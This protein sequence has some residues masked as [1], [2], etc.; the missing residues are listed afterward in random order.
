M[1]LQ[2]SNPKAQVYYKKGIA[3]EAS[4]QS[5][6]ACKSYE[7][8]AHLEP[9]HPELWCRLGLLSAGY[10]SKGTY[11][12]DE[13]FEKA[14]ACS[15]STAEPLYWR[16]RAAL[17]SGLGGALPDLVAS[18][19]LDPEPTSPAVWETYARTI[20]GHLGSLSEEDVRWFPGWEQDSEARQNPK[21]SW[22]DRLL[23]CYNRA[24]ALVPN[25]GKYYGDRGY[26]YQEH[27]YLVE[28]LADYNVA[29]NHPADS[30]SDS[31][32][33]IRRGRVRLLL[34]DFAGA[35][36]DFTANPY[37]NGKN[38]RDMH[39]HIFYPDPSLPTPYAR[40]EAALEAF[41]I[42][43]V[44]EPSDADYV[45]NRLEYYLENHQYRQALPDVEALIARQPT[46]PYFRI[47]H[48]ACHLQQPAPDF[49]VLLSEFEWL[50]GQR[51]KMLA[52]GPAWATTERI[53]QADTPE[54]WPRYVRNRY[55]Y[56]LCCCAWAHFNLGNH[57]AARQQFDAA[58]DFPVVVDAAYGPRQTKKG[59]EQL[60]DPDFRDFL[61]PVPAPAYLVWQIEQQLTKNCVSL[62]TFNQTMKWVE[63]AIREL[64]AAWSAGLLE[65]FSAFERLN[66]PSGTRFVN[67]RKSEQY[68]T[69][70]NLCTAGSLQT[71]ALGGVYTAMHLSIL[72]GQLRESINQAH[73]TPADKAVALAHYD[74]AR[75]QALALQPEPTPN[76]TVSTQLPPSLTGK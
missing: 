6:K 58:M 52:D 72:K 12:P 22:W 56:H 28:A 24:I 3:Y 25:Q 44:V 18:F 42:A 8:A 27:D 62:S 41:E 5:K 13:A 20:N 37:L 1:T 31:I 73:A 34:H 69:A 17:E 50:A 4:G 35:V 40:W 15:A 16:G 36:S 54:S 26:F 30:G 66:L 65:A 55:V 63:V 10:R 23:T 49:N 61:T 14:V 29:L 76:P 45:K 75:A 11:P 48:I 64:P 53:W 59:N 33:H 67:P 47:A 43:E 46:E 57:V 21:Y 7:L 32:N 68:S 74:H 70:L 60:E 9:T 71:P 2:L 38:W 19:A 39:T 51:D